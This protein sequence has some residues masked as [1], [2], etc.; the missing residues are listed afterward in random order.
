MRPCIHCGYCCRQA[1]CCY[2]ENTNTSNACIHLTEDNKC[3]IYDKVKHDIIS[4]A[5]GAGCCSPMNTDRRDLLRKA[6]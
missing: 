1:P 2:G 5:M 3:G 4:P 6:E